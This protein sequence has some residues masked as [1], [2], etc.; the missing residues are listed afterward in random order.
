MECHGGVTVSERALTS[1]LIAFNAIRYFAGN[2]EELCG[3]ADAL[4]FIAQKLNMIIS[5]RNS[6]N[7]GDF[8]DENRSRKSLTS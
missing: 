6:S 7:R 3:Q 4:K 1:S 8:S 5:G 2:Y